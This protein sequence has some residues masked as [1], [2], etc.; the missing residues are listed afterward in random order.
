MQKYDI[1]ITQAWRGKKVEYCCKVYTLLKIG[2]IQ[3]NGDNLNAYTM[4]PKANN[5]K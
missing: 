1:K 2:V 5:E 4:N 3:V